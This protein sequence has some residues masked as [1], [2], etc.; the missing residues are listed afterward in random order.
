MSFSNAKALLLIVLMCLTLSHGALAADTVA[1]SFSLSTE[2]GTVKLADLKG[3]VVYLDFWAS[4]C[5]PCRKSFPWMN[6]MAQ[7]YGQQDLVIV[8]VNVDK[9]RELAAK[10]LHEVPADFTVAYDPEGKVADSYQVQGMPSS[11]II[12]RSGHIQASHIGFREE[13]TAA[14]EGALQ[15]ALR[16]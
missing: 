4:W 1:P 7:R 10:F 3:K 15:R 5:P 8:A 13:D 6:E 9:T 14:L 12:D 2:T 11:F 16:P